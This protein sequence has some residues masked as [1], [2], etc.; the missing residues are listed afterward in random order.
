MELY[1]HGCLTHAHERLRA[2]LVKWVF[3]RLWMKGP[4]P[5]FWVLPGD[6]IGREIL[7]HGLFEKTTL[8]ALR[9]LLGK[10]KGVLL[11]IGANIGNHAVFFAPLF[12]RVVAFEPNP[13][14]FKILEANVAINKLAN[15]LPVN[16]GLGARA[17]KV[18]FYE[19]T[20]GNLGASGFKKSAGAKAIG[21]LDIAV[22]DAE[23]KRLGIKPADVRAVKIDVEGLETEV[24]KGLAGTLKAAKPLVMFEVLEGA[25]GASIVAALMK[26]GYGHFY[27]MVEERGWKGETCRLLKVNK[28]GDRYYALVI[29]SAAELS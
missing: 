8:L 10:Q 6:A 12:N 27:E 15:V 14:V 5:K 25:H 16:K 26:L 4:Y 1:K 23:L 24:I 3:R 18:P 11:D 20:G 17:G 28:L 9:K 2:R 19:N 29:A 13:A 7:T 21:A 22:G